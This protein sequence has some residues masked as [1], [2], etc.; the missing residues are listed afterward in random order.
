MNLQGDHKGHQ[1]LKLEN[2]W[3]NDNKWKWSSHR[4][5]KLFKKWRLL[6]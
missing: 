2:D 4:T 5:A 6:K 3:L 1:E